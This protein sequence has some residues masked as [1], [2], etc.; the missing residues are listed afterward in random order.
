MGS[1]FTGALCHAFAEHLDTDTATGTLCLGWSGDAGPTADSI[2]LRLCGGFHALVLQQADAAL[3]EAYPPHRSEIPDWSLLL[4]VLIRHETFFLDWMKSPPQTNEVSRSAVIWP[5]LMALAD[6]VNMP[7]SLLEVGA[8]GGLNLRSDRFGY[9]LGGLACGQEDSAL[10]LAPQWQGT[11]PVLAEPRVVLRQGCDLN[12]IDPLDPAHALRLRAYL[13]PDQPE[14]MRRLDAA[15]SIAATTP[16]AVEQADAVDWL[17]SHLSTLE[18]GLC[19]VVY[20]TVAWQYLPDMAQRAGESIILDAARNRANSEAPLA[21]VRF[22]ADGDT[23][24]GGI[25]LQLWPKGLDCMLGRA[26]FHAR[27]VDWN[28]L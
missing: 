9:D 13:W 7:L 17:A 19:T 26:D 12:P 4:E 6:R 8:S 15:L 20:S 1:P 23:P 10:H 28:G 22:E 16:A 18:S 2:P 25:R 14:R 3:V 27:W 24:G 5:A 21:W 11:V